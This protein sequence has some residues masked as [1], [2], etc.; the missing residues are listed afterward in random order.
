MP[1][2]PMEIHDMICKVDEALQANYEQAIA[3]NPQLAHL[4]AKP[5]PSAAPESTPFWSMRKVVTGS[6]RKW[7]RG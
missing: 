3:E 6:R 5:T 7:K 4:L 2:T 1:L